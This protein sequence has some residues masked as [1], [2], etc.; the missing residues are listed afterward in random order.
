MSRSKRIGSLA[1]AAVVAVSLV[2][3]YGLRSAAPPPAPAPGAATVAA[4]ALPA[5][6]TPAPVPAAPTPT[7]Y[8]WETF[9]EADGLPS[10]KGL[11]VAVDGE[12]VWIGTNEGL[13]L[14][15]DGA[16]TTY[17]KADGLGHDVVINLRL[18]ATTGDLWIA[19][20]AGLTRYSAGKFET[21]T[22][23]NSGLQNDMVYCVEVDGPHVW[24][25]TAAGISRLDTRS[26]Q[27]DIWNETNAPMHEPWT[28]GV[29][30]GPEHVYVGAWGGGLLEYDKATG[31]WKDYVDPDGEMEIDVFPDDG[32]VHD[33]VSFVDEEEGRVW[34]ATYFGLSLFDGTRWK[35]Y[36]EENSGL[37]GNFINFVKA[38]GPVGWLG[39]DRGLSSFDGTHWRTYTRTPDGRGRVVV[40]DGAGSVLRTVD[41]A[42]G[43][44]HDYVLGID[45]QGEDIWISTENGISRGT[46]DRAAD[47]RLGL[48]TLA[49]GFTDSPRQP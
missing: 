31:H 46:P 30:A 23:L 15:E 27:W 32:I 44:A 6:P 48:S 25:A 4:P 28:Y 10:Y 26:G 49:G 16:F 22:Q 9:T 38:R 12:R 24:A 45:F 14:Y 37:A 3:L 18:D 35:G 21:F 19:T 20:A 42:T 29:T 39:T 2:A 36:F 5:T 11:A 8:R 7:V 47:G 17:T 13:A 41:T 43:P 1:G 34:V 40:T 33:I